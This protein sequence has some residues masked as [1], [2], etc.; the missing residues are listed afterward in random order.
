MAARHILH[1]DFDAF[2]ASVE[3][4]LDPSLKGKP[5]IVEAPPERRGV[6]VHKKGPRFGVAT[7]RPWA[8]V[9]EVEG[10]PC[11]VAEAPHLR[12]AGYAGVLVKPGDLGDSRGAIA[13]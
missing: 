1:L 6:E 7:P 2:F 9:P 8:A 4:I 13:L 5:I 11:S 10:S 3:E 12:R